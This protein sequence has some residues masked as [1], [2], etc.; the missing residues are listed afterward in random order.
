VLRG[1]TGNPAWY[2]EQLASV[3]GDFT[4][5]APEELQRAVAMLA[6]RFAR[7]I[8]HVDVRPI[9]RVE[10]SLTDL[11]AAPR[12]P[13]E[14]APPAALV[15]DSTMADALVG[16]QIGDA[17]VV[18]TWFDRADRE[19]RAVHPRGDTSRDLTGVFATRSPDRPNP[20][21]LHTVRVTAI[22]GTRVGVD[23]LEALDGTPIVDVKIALGR[24]E[25]R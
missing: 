22:D 25:T 1:S 21:G 24:V 23:A 13:D 18:V 7:A 9:G 6:A 4:V 11:A 5:V 2:A 15:L 17:I 12:Q 20:V 14:G 3:P 10:S 8:D 19:V 16:L